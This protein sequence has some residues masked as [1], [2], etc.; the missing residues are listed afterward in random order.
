MR[1]LLHA[2]GRTR[3]LPLAASTLVGR[4]PT[5]HARVADPGVPLHWLEVRWLGDGWGWRALG[6]LGL[7]RGTGAV[8]SAGWRRMSV[9]AGRGTRVTLEGHAWVELL[10]AGPPAPFVVDLATG[11]ALDDAVLAQVVE[12]WRDRWLPVSADGDPSRTLVDGEVFV[13]GGRPYRVWIPAPIEATLGSR[14]DLR[15][16]GVDLEL[17]AE[18]RCATFVQGDAEAQVRGECV[19]V[20]AV[21]AAARRFGDGWLSP[22]EAWEGWHARGAPADAR[23]ERVGWERTRLRSALSRAG[24]AGLDQLFEVDRAGM[25]WRLRLAPLIRVDG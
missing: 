24:V 10:D 14:L 4:A 6:A 25:E 13:E 3:S 12:V 9:H 7:T 11:D 1:L 8:D 17:D 23:M 15:R 19:R 21:Y 18:G 5:C 16:G 22:Q 2:D 20:L